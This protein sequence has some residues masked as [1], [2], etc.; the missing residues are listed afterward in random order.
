M[1]DK[2]DIILESPWLDTLGTFTINT[3]KKFLSFLYKKN[4]TIFLDVTLKSSSEVVSSEDL[5]DISKMISREDK[6]S[7]QKRRQELDK[8]IM[9]KEEE[10]SPLRDHSKK[11]FCKSK[12]KRINFNAIKS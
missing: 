8:V 12:R 1:L 3:R 10:I 4:K 2:V 7:R 5:K 11:F 6:K 9:D